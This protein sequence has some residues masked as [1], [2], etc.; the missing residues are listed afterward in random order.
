MPRHEIRIN[1]RFGVSTECWLFGEL[2]ARTP[3][4]RAKFLRRLIELGSLVERGKL[5]MQR[6]VSTRSPTSTYVLH[7]E[8]ASEEGPFDQCVRG[9]LGQ[10]IKL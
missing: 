4:R 2:S 10:M 8:G 3:Y 6:P 9:A 5:P 7:E 1:L